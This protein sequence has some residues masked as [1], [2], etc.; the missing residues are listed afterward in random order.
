MIWCLSILHFNAYFW[1]IW[2]CLC[3]VSLISE[4]QVTQPAML[5][6]LSEIAALCQLLLMSPRWA[7]HSTVLILR[8]SL[9][10]SLCVPLG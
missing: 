6:A 10:I 9:S 1:R 8:M 7:A 4:L 3:R 5:I 2:R